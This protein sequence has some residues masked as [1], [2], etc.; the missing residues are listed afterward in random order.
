MEQNMTETLNGLLSVKPGNEPHVGEVR[1]LSWEHRTSKSGKPWIKIKNAGPDFGGTP[2]R[3]LVAEKTDFVDQHGNL[4]FR[5]EIEATQSKSMELGTPSAIAGLSTPPPE[6]P[7]TASGSP[8]KSSNGGEGV[9]ETRKHLMQ[10]AN[11]YN[12]VLD[13]VE[14]VIEPHA[15]KTWAEGLGGEMFRTTVSSL[16]IEAS[17][18]RTNDGVNWWSYVDKMP[19][20]PL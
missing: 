1:N 13:A 20:K 14:K 18:K 12:L 17:H 7:A 11:L 6:R 3:I 8:A 15:R 9:N 4:S 16:F 19:E 2:Y 10:S 5:V